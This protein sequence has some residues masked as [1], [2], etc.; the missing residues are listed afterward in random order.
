M[1]MVPKYGIE[2]KLKLADSA[3]A[4]DDNFDFDEAQ[5]SLSHKA[6]GVSFRVFD[7]VTVKIEVIE[8][9]GRRT[10]LVV[11]LLK[12]NLSGSA[13][14]SAGA[15]ASAS[16]GAEGM[17]EGQYKVKKGTKRDLGDAIGDGSASASSAKKKKKTKR[18]GN[19]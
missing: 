16:A 12:P 15:S 3:K 10:E 17:I 4:M 11:S 6:S 9:P 5:M 19:K 7:P 14:A 18:K 13:S 8:K 2:A 1:V